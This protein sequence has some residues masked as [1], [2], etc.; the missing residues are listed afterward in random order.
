MHIDRLL[1]VDLEA[2]CW[3]GDPPKG[4]FNEIIEVGN[5]MLDLRTGGVTPGPE[6]LVRPSVSK[7]SPFCTQLTSITQQMV[8][9]RGITLRDALARLEAFAGGDLKIVPWASYGD[10]DVITLVEH[11][12]RLGLD[13]PMSRSH[14]NVKRLV[15]MLCGWPKPVGMM[16]ALGKLKIQ[17][18]GTHHRGGDDAENICKLWWWVTERCRR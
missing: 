16:P 10:Y 15:A 18:T 9:E 12:R 13:F 7:V 11:C 6:L 1:V 8:D 3:E 14:T 5:A 17:H 4:Q 2:T